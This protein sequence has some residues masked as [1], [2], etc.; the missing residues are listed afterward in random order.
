[1]SKKN[2]FYILEGHAKIVGMV[3]EGQ[4]NPPHQGCSP[5]EGAK[6]FIR[7]HNSQLSGLQ[8]N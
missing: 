6:P 5:I 8:N 4:K 2:E 7:F 1:M 3:D